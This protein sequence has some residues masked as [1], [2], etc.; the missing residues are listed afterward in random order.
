MIGLTDIAYSGPGR[1][2]DGYGPGFFRIGGVVFRGAVIAAPDGVRLWAGL[3]DIAPLLAL[4]G[5]IDVLLLGMGAQ[6]AFADPAMKALVEAEEIALE[7]MTSPSAARS[8]N[9]LLSEGRRV[10]AAL[11]PV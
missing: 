2:I 7:P 10:A 1:P 9:I 5:Q 3:T 8:Y 11:L 4:Q 6:I